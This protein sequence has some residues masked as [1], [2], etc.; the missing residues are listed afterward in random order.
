MVENIRDLTGRVSGGNERIG[1]VE[2]VC[3]KS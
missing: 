2:E 1:C 3:A